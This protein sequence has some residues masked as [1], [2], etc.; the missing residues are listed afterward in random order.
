MFL[1]QPVQIA[2]G[3]AD[4]NDLD[5]CDFSDDFD[6]VILH[7]IGII[8]LATQLKSSFED[9]FHIVHCC[10]ALPICGRFIQRA[11]ARAHLLVA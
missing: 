3:M 2:Y 9:A 6:L 4:G 5:L 11:R 1:L 8:H 7:S 10:Q